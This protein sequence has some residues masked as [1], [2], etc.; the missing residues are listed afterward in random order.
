[1]LAFRLRGWQHP[2]TKMDAYEN[3]VFAYWCVTVSNGIRPTY[4]VPFI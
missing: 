2:D 3:V 4:D 1:M